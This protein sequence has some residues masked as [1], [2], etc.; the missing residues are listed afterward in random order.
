MARQIVALTGP[1]TIT[2][3]IKN[4]SAIS[5]DEIPAIRKALERELRA[6]GLTVRAQSSNAEVRLTLSQNAKGLL[7][8]AEVQEGS[9]L[10][11]AMLQLPA[12][13]G[14]TAAA[15]AQQM[16]LQDK[17]VL[18]QSE[19]VLDMAALTLANQ[20][21]MV[22]LEPEY[23]RWYVE[24]AGTLKLKQSFEVAH[25]NPF[26]RD[27]RGRVLVG[28]EHP[29]TAFL[30]G[31]VCTASLVE[32]A[33]GV[34][35]SC[36][37]SDD[38]WPLG[39]QKAFFNSTRNYFTGVLSPG[40]VAKL[41]QFYSAAEVEQNSTTGLLLVDLAGQAHAFDNGTYRN[42]IGAR[43]WGS[44]IAVVHS[45]CGTGT[46]IVASAA[47]WPVSDSLRAYQLAGHELTPVSAA[48]SFEGSVT[49]L[50]PASDGSSLTAVVQNPQDAQYEAHRVTVSCGR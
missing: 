19:P 47:G 40:V 48:L 46:Q 12:T 13:A 28:G 1:G 34:A 31:V 8:V 43:D 20:P 36:V 50:S 42:V 18:R 10:R 22:V 14:G 21:G 30:P 24:D 11:V 16:V 7:W 15:P 39:S 3:S 45:A 32:P 41:P 9:E 25:T 17:L 23:I 49:A 27:I 4:H 37:D 35:V 29:F 6:A 44:D 33:G 38:P 5:T 2:L 26:P